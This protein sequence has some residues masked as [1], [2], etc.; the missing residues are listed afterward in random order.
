MVHLP[1]STKEMDTIE[2]WIRDSDMPRASMSD[3]IMDKIGENRMR[4][5]H[6]SNVM[7]KTAIAV[8]AAAVL[9]AGIIGTG[10]V[11]PVMA[12]TLKQIPVI[13]SLFSGTNEE[14]LQTAME[15]GIASI[16]NLSVTHDGVTLRVTELLYD[17]TRLALQMERTGIDMASVMMP[18]Q[19]DGGKKGYMKQP[20]LL[21]DGKEIK[22]S[23]GA[24]G[25]VPQKDNT[26]LVDLSE[27]LSLPDQ[28]EL[29]V[30]TEVTQVKEPFVFKIPVKID[31]Q[32]LALEPNAT[33]SSGEFSYTVKQLELT[34]LSTR[35]VLD[36]TG[37][38]PAAPEQSGQY[39]PS[40]MYYDIVDDQ[41]NVLNQNQVDFFHRLPDT[42]Y[43]IDQLYSGLRATQ[44]SITIKPYTFTVKT[45]DWS[46][47]GESNGKL[48]DKTYIKDLELTIPVQP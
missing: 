39:S 43:H 42:A 6:K 12:A 26:I 30:Q 14:R 10:Y 11:S 3:Q 21:A 2:Q 17:G 18:Y 33:Q 35:L 37:A 22:F 31:N 13:G 20:T 47:V 34:P 46:I 19:G 7:K 41:G 45:S 44:K 28:F 1:E 36:S 38:V 16:P 27:G 25:E 5:K 40:M 8:S 9:G 32:T 23:K 4:N 24:F 15:Q 29:T 48:G